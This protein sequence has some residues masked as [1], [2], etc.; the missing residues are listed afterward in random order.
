MVFVLRCA[1]LQTGPP[2]GGDPDVE[3]LLGAVAVP[4]DEVQALYRVRMRRIR[5]GWSRVHVADIRWLGLGA[6]P[7]VQ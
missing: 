4:L 7:R 1:P 2:S 5:G 3:A 6:V